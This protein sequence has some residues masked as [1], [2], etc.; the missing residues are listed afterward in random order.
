M[1]IPTYQIHKILNTYCTKLTRIQ[2]SGTFVKTEPGT[3]QDSSQHIH[4][5]HPD[6]C[7]RI[8][9]K[10]ETDIIDRIMHSIIRHKTSETSEMTDPVPPVIQHHPLK[11]HFVFNAVDEHNVKTTHCLCWADCNFLNSGGIH[12][13]ETSVNNANENSV[14]KH[15]IPS[16][17]FPRPASRF[18]KQI[19]QQA[20]SK[21]DITEKAKNIE[22][23]KESYETGHYT[24]KTKKIVEKMLAFHTD[25]T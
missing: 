16:R 20:H 24:I 2:A 15:Q 18:L 3:D 10:I 6:K 25:S 14:G 23:I 22:K 9:N 12:P 4:T 17:Q 19:V 1:R 21:P 8:F 11:D 7:K 13:P 5:A